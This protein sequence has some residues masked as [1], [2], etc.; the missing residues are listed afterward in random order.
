MPCKHIFH[1]YD[2][3]I[4]QVHRAIIIQTD[5]KTS[6]HF[7]LQMIDV[8]STG[9]SYVALSNRTC[10]DLNH[11]ACVTPIAHLLADLFPL[12]QLSNLLGDQVS[13]IP[14]L[15]FATPLINLEPLHSFSAFFFDVRHTNSLNAAHENYLAFNAIWHCFINDFNLIKWLSN[16]FLFYCSLCHPIYC[17]D[18]DGKIEFFSRLLFLFF[19]HSWRKKNQYTIKLNLDSKWVH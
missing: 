15:L 4:L 17:I 7:C 13:L 3:N 9:I 12:S 6:S 11:P 10:W 19:F 5:F 1:V 2:K 16:S 18:V 8:E 14:H